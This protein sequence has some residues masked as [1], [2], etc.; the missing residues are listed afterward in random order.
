LMFRNTIRYMLALALAASLLSSCGFRRKKYDNPITKDTQQPDKVLFDKAVRDIERSRYEV[1]RLTLQTLI[2][3]YDTSE[4][5][6]KAKLAIADSWYREGGSHGLAQAEAE[7]KDFI[8]FYPTM[9]EAAEAQKKVCSIHYKQ[10]E[11]ADR[12]PRHALQAEDE[13]RQ[14]LVQFPNSKFAPEAQQMLRNIQEVLADHEYRTGVFYY[15]KGSFPAAANR[16]QTM[17]DQFPL[18]SQADEALWSLGDSYQRMGDRFENQ[19]ASAYTRIVKDYPLSPR[20]DQAKEK[21]LAMKRPVPEA[22]PVAYARMKYELENRDKPGMMSHVWGVFRKSPDMSAAA[23]S[24]SPQMTGMR[25]GIP[26][27]VPPAA[28]GS[29]TGVS[30]DVSVSTV[31]DGSQLDAGPDSRANPPAPKPAAETPAAPAAQAAEGAKPEGAA[32]TSGDA[33]AQSS[34]PLPTNRNAKPPKKQKVKKSKTP[35]PAQSTPQSQ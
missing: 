12:D 20:A 18:F 8:L 6:A 4:F 21:L 15:K 35:A 23:K 16:L 19:A 31:T 28:A 30:A 25:P 9:E 14:L 10:M 24:G 7:Y 13:C 22:D 3:T 1:A 34:T 11:K 2:N 17:S 26:A 27:S 32:A 33:S 29:G 5:L